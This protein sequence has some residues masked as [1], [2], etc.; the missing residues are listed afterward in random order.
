MDSDE[1]MRQTAIEALKVL[2][3]VVEP[4]TGK[5][6]LVWQDSLSFHC[7]GSGANQATHFWLCETMFSHKTDQLPTEAGQP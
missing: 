6:M 7:D 4:T 5:Q 3:K 1:E 2:Q